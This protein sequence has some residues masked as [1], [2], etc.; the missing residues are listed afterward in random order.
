MYRRKRR[1]SIRGPEVAR[2]IRLARLWTVSKVLL[3]GAGIAGVVLLMLFFG[4]PFIEDLLTGTD[5]SLRYVP[6]LQADFTALGAAADGGEIE[7]Q[8]MYLTDFPIKNEP[9]IAGD[10]IIFT[11]RH[12]NKDVYELDTVVVFDILTGEAR[13]LPGVDKKY[14]NLLQPMLSGNIAVW[15]DSLSAGGGR[16][17]GYDLNTDTQ[18]IIKDY[19]YAMPKL[20]LSGELLAFMQWAG[21]STQRLYVYNVR[22][23]EPVTVKL[24]Q[25]NPY[26]NSAAS[27]SGKDLVWSEYGEDGSALLKRIVF[28]DG[29]ARYENYDLHVNVFEPKTNGRDIVFT[30]SRSAVDG[31]LMLSTNGGEPVLI[32]QNVSNYGIGDNF[33]AY[34]KG[35]RVYVCF[36]DEQNV[37]SL[38]SDISKT[39]LSC[40]NGRAI[41][42]YDVTDGVLA[43]EVVMYATVR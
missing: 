29:T 14:D 8:E 13:I 17:V 27:V 12:G 28:A 22:T 16:V 34:T 7:P 20:S 37:F 39:L 15:L 19:G 26:G 9:Y 42:Y 41:T 32:A 36:T 10:Q 11:T 1:G 3:I 5:P 43:D 33:I 6:T 25:N 23:R 35:E 21:D 40:A 38:T 24:Y 4:F 30:T 2:S 18:F 31:S